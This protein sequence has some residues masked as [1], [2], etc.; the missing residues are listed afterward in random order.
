MISNIITVN[1]LLLSQSLDKDQYPLLSP[2]IRKRWKSQSP[3]SKLNHR[4][5]D[6]PHRTW[7]SPQR[8]WDLLPRTWR[9]WDL[10]LKKPQ[11]KTR[12]FKSWIN[13]RPSMLSNNQF[14]SNLKQNSSKLMMRSSEF[15]KR[16]KINKLRCPRR[17]RNL[18]QCPLVMCNSSQ[19][20]IFQWIWACLRP[21]RMRPF[22]KCKKKLSRHPNNL[23]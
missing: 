3:R 2:K 9:K 19:A 8:K 21:K 6:S 17:L 1:K 10:S 13:W 20:T 11:L 23:S 14:L 15:K 7:D 4:P 22:K 18:R 12:I 16:R 5:W